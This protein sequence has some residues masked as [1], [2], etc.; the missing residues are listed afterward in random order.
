M[1]V[2]VCSGCSRPMNVPDTAAGKMARC[3]ACDVVTPDPVPASASPGNSDTV[4][5][6]GDHDAT[7]PPDQGKAMVADDRT[8][9]GY[10]VLSELGRG[11]MGVVYKARQVA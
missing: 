11:G 10:E 5:P 8:P 9:P 3:P 6:A 7:V 4:P 1:L 2:L